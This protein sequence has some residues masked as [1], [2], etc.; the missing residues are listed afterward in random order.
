MSLPAAGH[1]RITL[2]VEMSLVL[3]VSWYSLSEETMPVDS[4]E[5]NDDQSGGVD[6]R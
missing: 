3:Y 5:M 2:T 1:E 4:V 6:R